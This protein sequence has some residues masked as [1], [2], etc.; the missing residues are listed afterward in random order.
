MLSRATIALIHDH[1]DVVK[2]RS[3]PDELTIVCPQPGCADTTGNRSI[4]IKSG[5]TN[6]WRCNVGGLFS[7]WAKSLGL[8]VDESSEGPGSVTDLD[9]LADSIGTSE[10][11]GQFVV[12]VEL[13][14]GFTRV[15][16]DP[17]SAYSRLIEQMAVRKNLELQD[18][19]QFGVGFTRTNPLWEPFAIF[20]VFEHGRVVYY[21]GRTYID[22]P[23]EATKRFPSRSVVPVGSASF[24]HN[25]DTARKV[26]KPILII[27][28]SILNVISLS[29]VFQ[30]THVVPVCCFKH[31]LSKVQETKLLA[32]RGVQE[33]CIMFD[34][35]SHDAAV[36]TAAKL[37]QFKPAS[38]AKIEPEAGRKTKDAND[39]VD[40]AVDAFANRQFFRSS[41]DTLSLPL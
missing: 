7:R 21:Q 30:G 31:A 4:N 17:Y 41:V 5:L 19:T 11:R 26:E 16:D 40:A 8:E 37:S 24:L 29:K 35:D 33:V 18:L 20:P 13:P 1:F 15:E 27:V 39:D 12:S 6:C 32:I 38:V 34:A 9:E 23:G 25:L 3:T 14:R 2:D 36:K 22:K 28:E 10:R